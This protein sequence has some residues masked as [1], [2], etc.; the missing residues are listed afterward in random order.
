MVDEGKSHAL[1]LG[2]DVSKLRVL[3]VTTP[4]NLSAQHR[5]DVKK[6][7]LVELRSP[8]RALGRR[9]ASRGKRRRR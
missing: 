8:A 6:G 5:V 2:T 9:A 4:F 7:I 1:A 3:H